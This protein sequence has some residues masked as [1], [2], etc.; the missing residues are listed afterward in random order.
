M[1][2]AAGNEKEAESALERALRLRPSTSAANTLA[3]LALRRRELPRGIALL[4]LSLSLQPNQPEVLHQLSLAYGLAG[5]MANARATA[6]QLRQ[7]APGFPGLAQWLQ[8]LG[9]GR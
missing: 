8:S 4:R 3:T 9:L 2:L 1:L 5:D 7:L 6:L